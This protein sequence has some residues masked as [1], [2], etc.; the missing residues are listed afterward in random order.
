MKIEVKIERIA[1]GGEGVGRLPDGKVVFVP[2]TAP[3]DRVEVEV[4]RSEKRFSRAVVTRLVA[5][6]PDRIE[7]LCP[8]YDTDG[9]GSC[10]FQHLSYPAQLRAK[11]AIVGDS[12]RRL[13]GF[14]LPD[15]E[16]EAADNP[17][18]YRSKISLTVKGPSPSGTIGFHSYL[19]PD[20]VFDLDDCLIA[21]DRV[22]RAWST[23][24]GLRDRFP[25]DLTKL[26]IKETG[27]TLQVIFWASSAGFD[28]AALT[29]ALGSQVAIWLKKPDDEVALVA[30]DRSTPPLAF[31]QSSAEMAQRI[32]ERACSALGDIAD[33]QVLD[34][35]CGLG[36]TAGMLAKRGGRVTAVDSDVTAIAYARRRYPEV[37]FREACV[38]NDLG[39]LGN[40]AAITLNP[41]R[42]GL[43]R[44]VRQWL[45][46]WSARSAKRLVYI[47]CD[48]ATLARDLKGMDMVPT[49]VR[50]YDL[51]PQTS[52]VETLVVLRSG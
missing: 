29:E 10:Q 43:P 45:A 27:E 3:G 8:H 46:K 44:P 6:G 38:E 22:R 24:A 34:L 17:W 13:G 7:P 4:I 41:P 32:R 51:F 39:N 2:R 19:D 16:I 14:D 5:G 50:A 33:S 30:G 23:L 18:G 52:H 1:S 35:F 21:T 40:P 49:L 11:A 9:C 36:V 31:E 37:V 42:S 26:A 20:R 48:A 25:S 15:P 12:L 47:S 28:G